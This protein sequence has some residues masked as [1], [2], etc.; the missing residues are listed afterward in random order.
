MCTCVHMWVQVSWSKEMGTWSFAA[1]L[2]SGCVL[3]N[4][5][6][7]NQTQVFY[8]TLHALNHQAISLSSTT[9]VFHTA[10]HLLNKVMR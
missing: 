1:G 5:R 4:M 8:K 9:T 10:Q 6:V 2:T 3:P 7:G